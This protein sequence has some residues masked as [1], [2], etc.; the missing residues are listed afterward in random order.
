[1]EKSPDDTKKEDN[2]ERDLAFR[3]EDTT[4]SLEKYER[5]EVNDGRDGMLIT[6]EISCC[7]LKPRT[8]LSRFF[9]PRVGTLQR[10]SQ[11]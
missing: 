6:K 7:R 11:A 8:H 4:I 10:R 9:Y 2:D 1:M 5:Q 3:R